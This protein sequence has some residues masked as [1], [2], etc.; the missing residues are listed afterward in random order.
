M[1]RRKIK[2]IPFKPQKK[3]GISGQIKK[4]IIDENKFSREKQNNKEIE[5]ILKIETFLN[6]NL[7]DIFI[8]FIRSKKHKREFTSC[9]K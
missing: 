9:Q 2:K 4:A 3:H 6:E 7:K 1:K 5:K 8:I